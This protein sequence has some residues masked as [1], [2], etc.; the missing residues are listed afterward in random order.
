MTPDGLRPL[1]GIAVSLRAADAAALV[2]ARHLER[3]GATVEP[4]NERVADIVLVEKADA[5][6]RTASE[7]TLVCVFELHRL[8]GGGIVGSET[9]AQAAMGLTDYVGTADAPARTGCAVG[10]AVAGFCAVQAVLAWLYGGREPDVRHD[11]RVSALRAISTLKTILWAARSRPDAWT[12]THLTS[13]DRLEDS[14]YDTRE[15]RITLDFPLGA[16]LPWLGFVTELGLAPETIER[17]RP[18]W[19]ES[20]GWGDDVDLARPLY[21]EKLAALTSDDA[22]A[23]VRRN[24]GSSVPFL[25]PAECLADPQAEA[26]GLVES[27]AEGLPWRLE[28]AGSLCVPLPSVRDPDRPLAGVR[29]VDFG[30]G[31]V[32]PFAAT[33]LA[34]LGADVVKVEAPNEFILA[35]R[36]TVEGLSSTYLAINQG[37]RSVALNLKDAD[38]LQLARRLVDEADVVIEN[39]RP[40]ALGRLGLGPDDVAEMSARVVYCSATGFG[41]SGPLRDEPCTDPH[42]QAFSGFAS[43]NAETE[44]GLPRRVRYYGFVDLVTSTVIAEAVCAGLL[45]RATQGGPVRIQTS[46]LHAVSEAMR[47]TVPSAAS[48]EPDGV[49][50]A[51]DGFVALTC[52]DD[53]E[54]AALVDALDARALLGGDGLATVA[55]RRHAREDVRAMLAGVLSR[56]PAAAWEQALGRCGVPCVRALHD[57]EVL[58]RRDYWE[59]GLLRELPIADGAPLVA[60]G[61][62]WR[63][64]SVAPAPPAPVPGADTPALRADPSAFWA[65]RPGR[66]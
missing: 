36:P 47:M 21:E 63:R 10:S 23:L 64:I 6:I 1:N 13:R 2:A 3:L 59:A 12:G 52:R 55:G 22:I 14:G 34:W 32:G 18:R 60:G 46:M 37:K 53:E 15:R 5:E 56:R 4:G 20:V 8:S 43:L 40:G 54:W 31:G 7:G 49:F 66:G 16:E 29:V 62:P 35:V 30:V 27:L 61:P 42:M 51:L 11:V 39:F 24:G 65:F 48:P 19:I 33:L 25:S 50:P 9:M 17:L 26:L 58:G 44:S 28:A 41:W 57:D 38:D 45:A